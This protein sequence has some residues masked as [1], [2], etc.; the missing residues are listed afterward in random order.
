MLRVL[1]DAGHGG[2]VDG[3]TENGVVEDTYTMQMAMHVQ[4][5]IM[6]SDWPIKTFLTRTK[7]VH[8]SHQDRARLASIH[9]CDFAVSLH[10]NAIH[11]DRVRGAMA[12]YMP[13]DELSRAV[14]TRYVRAA[15]ME[16]LY[17][18]NSGSVLPRAKRSTEAL[19]DKW[20]RVVKV[21]RPYKIP[22]A[23]YEMGF[24]TN[25][26]DAD[27]L[28]SPAGQRETAAAI[29]ASLVHALSIHQKIR[30]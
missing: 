22:C 14:G 4:R 18:S 30:S 20:P 24:S 3:T 10:V 7:D 19:V 15:D 2:K 8:V 9:E 12:F 28:L 1:L 6:G 25:K 29:I 16:S 27:W 13:H 26:K 5:Q 11:D 17:V 23:L 21:L